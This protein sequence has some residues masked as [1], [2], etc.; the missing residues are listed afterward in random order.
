MKDM[1]NK[2]PLQYRDF[3]TL[4]DKEIDFIC[5]EILGM[6]KVIDIERYDDEIEVCGVSEWTDDETGETVKAEDNIALTPSKIMGYSF[7][8]SS[9]ESKD[10]SKYL[11]SLGMDWRLKDNPYLQ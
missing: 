4:T 6:K 10:Y 5:K 1:S 9:K 3:N 2:F 8:I 7:T 11:F